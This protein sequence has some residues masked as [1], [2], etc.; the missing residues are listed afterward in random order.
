MNNDA[1]PVDA[2]VNQF[3][4]KSRP[5]FSTS[6]GKLCLWWGGAAL[7]CGT[8][9]WITREL[10]EGEVDSFDV[11]FLREVATFHA[12]WLLDAAVNLT[13]FGSSTLVT[14]IS[15]FTLLFLL[16]LRD[17]LS[18]IQVFAA[19]TGAVILTFVTKNSIERLRPVEAQQLI[20][21]SGFSYPSGHTLSTTALY[22]TIAIVAC[23][24]IQG[25]TARVSIASAALIVSASVAASRV[26]LGV[27]YATDVASGFML[28]AAWALLL[29]GF[30]VL[31]A[32][33]R[34]N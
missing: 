7:A 26:S 21:V 14:L 8:F 33:R 19:S 17:H 4:T 31:Y 23:R 20:A 30:A 6:A 2:N 16:V 11:A 27:H 34:P 18:A 32:S 5:R 9:I 3:D 22:L 10:S 28:G 25:S 24:Y 12:P 1:R 15:A 13:A 29:N